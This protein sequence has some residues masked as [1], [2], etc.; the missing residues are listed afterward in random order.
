MLLKCIKV[1]EDLTNKIEVLRGNNMIGNGNA[2]TILIKAIFK[3]ITLKGKFPKFGSPETRCDKCMFNKIACFPASNCVGCF[4]G[5]K[6]EG[7]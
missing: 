4:H 2:E 1:S 5:W 7:E 6:R 3:N